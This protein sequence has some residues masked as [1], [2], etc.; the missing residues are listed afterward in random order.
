MFSRVVIVISV[1]AL[2][3]AV[4]TGIGYCVRRHTASSSGFTTGGNLFSPML[5]AALMLSEF[6]G[7]SVSIDT[8][9]NGFE[10]GIFAAW[11][12]VALSIGFLLLG[13]VL[14]AK[15]PRTGLNTISAIL[16]VH[17]RQSQLH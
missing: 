2:Y 4:V 7:S 1:F 11:S 10:E 5:I 3:F 15:Y 14:V 6:L 8:T 12:V 17:P 13:S 9:Q 16:E